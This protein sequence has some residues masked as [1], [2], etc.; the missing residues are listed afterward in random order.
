MLKN[1]EGGDIRV[2]EVIAKDVTAG[3]EGK[4]V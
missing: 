4:N 1:M 3:S 2:I